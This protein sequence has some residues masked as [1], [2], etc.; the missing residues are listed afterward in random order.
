MAAFRLGHFDECNKLL[1]E[2][3]QSPKLKESLAQGISS[4][5][6]QAEKTA[7]EEMEEKKR[8]VPPHLH[9]NL[10]FLDCAYLATS[11]L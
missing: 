1:N 7:E 3:T 6:R 4:H 8:Y 5:S 10:E 2:V 9:I 11:M